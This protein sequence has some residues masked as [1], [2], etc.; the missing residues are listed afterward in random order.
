MHVNNWRT[1]SEEPARIFDT[2]LNRKSSKR[3]TTAEKTRYQDDS[4]LKHMIERKMLKD[5][6]EWWL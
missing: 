4:V 1:E 3:R 6:D 2:N 5:P